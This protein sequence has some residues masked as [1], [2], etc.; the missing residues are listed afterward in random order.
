MKLTVFNSESMP[1][2]TIG[3]RS[4][5]PKISIGKSGSFLINF[6]GADRLELKH[7][8]KISFAQD[9]DGNWYVFKDPAGFTV[10]LHSDKKSLTFNHGE[11]ARTIKETLDLKR[12][13]SAQFFIAGQP[14]VHS[15][16]K[17]WGLI[18]KLS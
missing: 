6:S 12:D 15:K 18:I 16:V 10:R 5:I 17:Y 13:Q 14:E 7:G 1:Q 4:R 2:G 8:D 3:D 9:D 11:M